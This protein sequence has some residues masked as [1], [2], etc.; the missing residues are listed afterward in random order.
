M[1]RASKKPVDQ[2]MPTFVMQ[3][4]EP[5]VQVD[6]KCEGGNTSLEASQKRYFN[7]PEAFN[8]PNEQI[9]QVPLCVKA[10]GGSAAQ[11]QCFLMTKRQQQFTTKG[12]SKFVFPDATGLGYYRFS[13][14]TKAFQQLGASVEQGLTPEERIALIGDN[15][16][17]MRAGEMN[18]GD[19]LASGAQLKNT[20]GYVLLENFTNHLEF[21]YNEL[22]P[23]VNRPQM[24]AW[25]RQTF[26]PMMQQL[27]YSAGP[28]DSPAERQNRAT[29]FYTL[30]VMG[31][32]PQVVRQSQ[33]LVQQYMKDPQSLDPT[34]ARAVINVAARHGDAELYS[35]FKAQMKDAKTP[36]M[37]YR[38]F[39]ALGEFPEHDLIQQTIAS[40]L[41]PDVRGQDLH[42]LTNMM[43]N[44]EA[45]DAAWEFMRKNYDALSAKTGGGLGGFGIFL[46]AAQ[47]FCSQ[48]KEQEVQQFFQDHPIQGTE[49]NQKEALESI[50]SCAGLK[51]QQE[52]SLAAWLKQNAPTNASLG[53]AKANGASVR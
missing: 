7:T 32:D 10:V 42:I 27:G 38:Y 29:L 15:W 24:E 25:L 6:T 26:S 50:H 39:Y 28:N 35:Q 17:L 13:Y 36:E 19:Y 21:V 45:R 9:W 5:Y 52:A 47:N 51:Q 18:V 40:T 2:I 34:L 53:G 12:C 46:G 1:A 4:G 14:D 30:G 8:A 37:Y 33:T 43:E 22:V 16:A 20:P 3:A 48:D 41:T 23:S 44:P 11:S 49:R 31:D